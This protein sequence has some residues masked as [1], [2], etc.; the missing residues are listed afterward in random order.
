M[1]EDGEWWHCASADNASDVNS[2]L[3]TRVCDLGLDSQWQRGPAYLYQDRALWP[4]ER[5]FADQKAKVEVPKEEVLKKYRHLDGAKLYAS[6]L[7]LRTQRDHSNFTEDQQE[8]YELYKTAFQERKRSMTGPGSLDN[9]VLDHFQHGYITNDWDKLLRKTGI[10]MRWRLKVMKA[11]P[12]AGAEQSAAA[13]FWF[14]TAMPAT[15]E[16]G[17]KGKLKHLTPVQ[18][19]EYEDL[20]VVRGRALEGMK[21]MYGVDYLPILMANT[22]DCSAGDAVGT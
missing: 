8:K 19:D 14:R 21:A 2:R 4:I 12:L 20:L 10:L 18:H 9:G 16:A 1:G 3:D 5:K 6:E 17:K 15:W 22:R 7:V 11:S 13:V